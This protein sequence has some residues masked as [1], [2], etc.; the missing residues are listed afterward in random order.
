MKVLTTKH[1]IT[2]LGY[3]DKH[4]NKV[5]LLNTDQLPI[6]IDENYAP[7]LTTRDHNFTISTPQI[8]T[9]LDNTKTLQ[10]FR[11]VKITLANILIIPGLIIAI[12]F[13]LKFLGVLDQYQT[14]KALI[15]NKLVSI[16][17]WT[18]VLGI[19]LLWHD[20]FRTKSHPIK[21]P[22]TFE[23]T[24][25]EINDIKTNGFKFTRYV[26]LNTV[27]FLSEESQIYLANNFVNDYLLTLNLFESMLKTPLLAEIVARSGVNITKEQ[28]GS[29]GI[30]K[31]TVPDYAVSGLRSLL[32][33]ALD[34]ALATSC[35]EIKLEHLFL[36][37]I[38]TFPVFKRLL[39]QTNTPIEFIREIVRNENDE[40]MKRKGRNEFSPFV[41]YYKSG[42]FAK[43]WIYGF[44]FVLNHFSKDLNYEIASSTEKYGIGHEKEVESIISIIGRISQKNILLIGEPGVGKS[45]LIQGLAQRIN[46]SQVP[47]QLHNK[48]IIKM[49]ITRLIATANTTGN[50][51]ALLQQS[52]GELEK[53]GNT[54]LYIDEI[55]ELIPAKAEK[56]GHS[57]A[58][59]MLPY[60]LDG[61][62]PIIGTI[63]YADYKKYFYANESLR[64]S[65]ET[66]EVSELSAQDTLYILESQIPTIE[67]NFNIFVTFPALV[68][69]IEFS[70]RYITNRKLPDSAVR[71]IEGACSWAQS[72]KITV[73]TGEHV[74]KYISIQTSVP[75]E[76]VTAEEATQLMNLEEVMK[77]KVI[78]QDAAVHSIVET[79]KRARLDIRDPHKPIGVFLFM[80]PTGTGKTH[81]AK[82]LADQY[83]GVRSEMIKVDMSEFQEV[84]S[85]NK[86]LGVSNG[87]DVYGQ[88]SVTLLDRIKTTPYSVVLFD[89]IEKAHPQVLDLFLQLFDE[90]RLT[91]NSGET[92]N[93]TNTIIICT[94]NI[95]S[96][97]MMDSLTKDKAMWETA[98]DRA[99]IELRQA[100]RPEFLN[101]FDD[102][103]VFSPH[104]INNLTI[105]AEILLQD[106]AKRIGEK[107]IKMTWAKKVPM[108]IAEKTNQ[109]EMGARPLKRFIQ[110]KVE[111]RIA[112]ELLAGNIESGSEIEVKEEWLG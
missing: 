57:I 91:S 41:P 74:A 32:T 6:L 27:H 59:I 80:G 29:Y 110:E 104:D 95:G 79:L 51:D 67:R 99:L 24:D 96:K 100:V 73:L 94:S 19:I 69:A 43:D 102:V 25:N 22:N 17:F 12:L 37:I 109:P 31:N 75:V 71:T 60:I 77:K 39:Q 48:R 7:F 1:K 76:S 85:I 34:E 82:V 2:L 42:G 64:Q 72:Q 56:S 58:S 101:R 15:S 111:G 88:S 61:K 62:F 86:F 44:T 45:S 10:N 20:Y 4:L 9:L 83:F 106:L 63:N 53:S 14:V 8:A 54:I 87:D 70:Q 3:H 21:L 26:D 90:G 40:E 65:F 105:I 5:G 52:M 112:T 33:Y 89:E 108:V 38:N 50:I 103:I 98:K 107:G 23:L 55:Q 68:S 30:D 78:G 28:F 18:A 13:A 11:K 35:S 16:T 81:L 36:A 66:I 49:D 97:I 93:F 84:S 47:T 46:H 92:V